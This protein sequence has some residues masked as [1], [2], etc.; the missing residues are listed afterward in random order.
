MLKFIN[1]TILLPVCMMLMSGFS[2]VHAQDTNAL[3]M[4]AKKDSLLKDDLE[5]TKRELYQQLLQNIQWFEI[6]QDMGNV[7]YNLGY[8]LNIELSDHVLR[9]ICPNNSVI[10][11]R[12]YE[13]TDYK[14][15]I[16]TTNSNIQN[17]MSVTEYKLKIGSSI[18]SVRNER[19]FILKSIAGYLL[20]IQ[21]L[22]NDL[23]FNVNAFDQMAAAYKASTVKPAIS[24]EQRKNIIQ[25]EAYAKL[26]QYEKAIGLLRRVISIHPTADPNAYLDIAILFAETN[27]LYSAVYN[28]KKFLLLN[29][30]SSDE[31]YAKGRISE[32]EI[33]LNN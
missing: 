32:W 27:R 14:L 12:F 29:P 9:F 20:K 17:G 5:R 24:E 25:A 15:K 2:A 4:V 30:G 33:M 3:N 1:S 21:K 19:Q 11:I 22:T 6:N 23:G 16:F 28:M 10:E 26:Y 18:I 13:M 7:S 8:P 31:Q